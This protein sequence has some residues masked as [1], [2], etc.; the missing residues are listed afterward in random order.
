MQGIFFCH[1]GK[2]YCVDPFEFAVNVGDEEHLIIVLC[3]D[4]FAGYEVGEGTYSI[5]IQ[6]NNKS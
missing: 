2:V 6:I 1:S 3:G 4:V 5:C